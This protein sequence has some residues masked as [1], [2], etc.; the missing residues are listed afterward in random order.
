MSKRTKYVMSYKCC[1]DC[2]NRPKSLYKHCQYFW[3]VAGSSD[4]RSMCIFK[5]CSPKFTDKDGRIWTEDEIEEEVNRCKAS[6]V[7][8]Y[9]KYCVLL[10]KDGNEVKKP[11]LSNLQIRAAREALERLKWFTPK[12]LKKQLTET[13][14]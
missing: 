4:E 10:D 12:V 3:H 14:E 1:Q 6:P 7:Y 8:F 9:N 13:K 11:R 2:T 5:R